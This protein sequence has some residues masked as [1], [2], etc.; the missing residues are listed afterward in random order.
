MDYFVFG[1]VD[2]RNFNVKIFPLNI[3]LAP[4]VTQQKIAVPG[5]NGDLLQATRR[6]ENVQ[7][8]YTGVIYSEKNNLGQVTVSAE[9]KMRDFRNALLKYVGYARLE[10]SINTDEFY[11]AHY[12]GGLEPELALGRDMVKFVIEFDRKPQRFL[13]S[14]ELQI[15]ISTSSATITN[16]T[17][18]PSKPLIRI[19]GNGS[20]II[21]TST[22]TVSE[23][24][25]AYV[26]VD[27]EMMDCFWVG[28][29]LNGKV[30]LSGY[31]FPE[32]APGN[33]SVSKS[34]SVSSI[35]ITPRWWRV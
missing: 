21:G 34:G 33:V 10:D 16:P 24:S 22:I 6:F 3:D 28:D 14:G 13:K 2:T 18:Y 9:E 19:Y 32:I 1:D 17:L 23:N 20:V 7:H 30:S 35:Y 12:A 25:R 11:Q 5:R 26:D 27:C 8:R 29:N 15:S 4:E 31:K